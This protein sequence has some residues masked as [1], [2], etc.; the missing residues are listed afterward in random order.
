MNPEMG[1]PNPEY[2][3]VVPSLK[4]IKIF[5]FEAMGLLTH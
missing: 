5:S 4:V 3:D 1:N 2:F